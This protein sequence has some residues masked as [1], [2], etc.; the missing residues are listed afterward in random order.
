MKYPRVDHLNEEVYNILYEW[1]NIIMYTDRKY[2]QWYLLKE[3]CTCPFDL[4]SNQHKLIAF[5]LASTPDF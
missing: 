3:N 2:V 1:N 5:L 4:V